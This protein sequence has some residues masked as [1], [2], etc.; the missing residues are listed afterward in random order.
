MSVQEWN[1]N[2]INLDLYEGNLNHTDSWTKSDCWKVKGWYARRDGEHRNVCKELNS[3]AQIGCEIN[4]DGTK[5]ECKVW[6]SY[7]ILWVGNEGYL[8]DTE[9]V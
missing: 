4:Y 1:M 7:H 5:W 3:N 2:G 9:C 6:S 8:N